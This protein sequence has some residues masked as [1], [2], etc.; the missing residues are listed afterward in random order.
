MERTITPNAATRLEQI[1]TS[2]I[3]RG[4][5]TPGVRLPAVRALARDHEVN[6]A[7]VQR[8]VARLEATGLVTARRGSG[9]VVNDPAECGDVS[10][11]PAWLLAL[12]DRPAEA[13]SVLDEFLEVRRILIARLI[14]R[15]REALLAR[16]EELRPLA[17]AFVSASALG[18]DPLRDAD[19]AFARAVLRIV[20]NRV[21]LA[22][23]HTAEAVV[24]QAPGVADAMYADPEANRR[25]MAAVLGSLTT[26]EGPP[27]AQAV[28]A[29]LA[30]VD[31]GTVRRYRALLENAVG[32]RHGGAR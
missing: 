19:M 10:L 13:T 26:L 15:H 25:S 18:G 29:A 32:R 9:V 31:A 24:R 2:S 17:Q 27:L 20:G 7:T 11:V 4:E 28:E 8:A 1:L 6:P 22:V 3:L 12:S 5:L 23:F 14:V 16:V 30:E 21:V